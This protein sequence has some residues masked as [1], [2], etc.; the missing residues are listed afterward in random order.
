MFDFPVSGLVGASIKML[1]LLLCMKDLRISL[2]S[3]MSDRSIC[4]IVLAVC[5]V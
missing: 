5:D 1:L 2:V 3:F 4:R